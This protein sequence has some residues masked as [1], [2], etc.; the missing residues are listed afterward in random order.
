MNPERKNGKSAIPGLVYYSLS[1]IIR[2]PTMEMPS[3]YILTQHAVASTSFYTD[4][5]IC[6]G[7]H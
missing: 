4:V 3:Q 2:V 7:I 1:E 6:E 5:M